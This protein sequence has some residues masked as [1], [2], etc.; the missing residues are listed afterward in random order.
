MKND[1]L[2]ARFKKLG[3]SNNASSRE[4]YKFLMNARNQIS[5]NQTILD[6]GAGEC[7]Y[8][9]FFD[10]CQYIAID[11]GQGDKRWNFSKLDILADITNLKFIK[12]E[13]V[14]YCLNTVTLEHINEPHLFFQEVERILKPGGKL[15]LY[16]PFIVNEH[17]VPYD[18]FRYTSY[19]LRYLSQQS[20]LEVVS[21][22]P[23]NGALSTGINIVHYSIHLS[24]GKN[25]FIKLIL[26]ILRLCFDALLPICEKLDFYLQKREFPLLWLL[27]AKKPGA[28]STFNERITKK[29]LIESIVRCP[30]CSHNLNYFDNYSICKNCRK[31]IFKKNGKL[32]F[33]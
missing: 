14:D 21:L 4:V 5:S 18:F 32:N 31:K 6:L 16:A 27:V 30:E 20:G 13:S 2:L 3:W 26:F 10:K 25:I 33:V 11:F 23:S 28:L 15:F 9:F 7:R 29:R 24:A 1:N 8:S 19:G 22:I 12:D 17:Q